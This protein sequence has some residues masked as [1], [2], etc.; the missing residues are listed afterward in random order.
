MTIY[1]VVDNDEYE[2]PV[3][4]F[5][6]AVDCAKWIGMKNNTDIHKYIRSGEPYKKIYKIIKIMV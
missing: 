4:Q 5:E 1:Q 3:A 2:L 6:K